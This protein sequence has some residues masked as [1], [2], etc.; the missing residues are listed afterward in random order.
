MRWMDAPRCVGCGGPTRFVRPGVPSAEERAGGAGRVELYSCAN[1]PGL[2][3][4]FPRYNACITLARTR[5]GRCGEWANLFT[6]ICRALGL[7][8]R[9]VMDWTDHVRCLSLSLCMCHA[10]RLRIA[11]ALIVPGGR[12]GKSR[13][14]SLAQVWTEVY[15]PS[16]ERYVH[17]DPCEASLDQ[18]L[19]YEKGWNKKLSFVVAFGEAEVVDVTRRYTRRFAE[20]LRRRAAL[21][22]DEHWARA[23]LAR[24]HAAAAPARRPPLARRLAEQLQLFFA[25]RGPDRPGETDAL[26]GRIS[27][28]AEWRAARGEGGT[29]A[30]WAGPD[31]SEPVPRDPRVRAALAQR[32][33]SAWHLTPARAAED[34]ALVG[35][36]RVLPQAV[37]L[38]PRLQSQVGAVWR[39]QPLR[40]DAAFALRAEVQLSEHGADGMALCIQVRRPCEPSSV[41]CAARCRRAARDCRRSARTAAVL[42]TRALSVA[43]RSSWCVA[44]LPRIIVLSLCLSL[45]GIAAQDTYQTVDRT[46]DPSGNHVALMS[47][48]LMPATA[49]HARGELAHSSDVPVLN[50]GRPHSLRL[51]YLPPES[52]GGGGLLLVFLDRRPEPLL[53]HSLSAKGL[54]DLLGARE[55]FVGFTAATG[56][57]FQEHDLLSWWIIQARPPDSSSPVDPSASSSPPIPSHLSSSPAASRSGPSASSPAPESTSPAAPPQSVSSS[58]SSSSPSLSS[59]SSSPLLANATASL[60]A[61]PSPQAPPKP[62][63]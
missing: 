14:L 20:C 51:E 25:G 39:R 10:Y 19:L 50:D 13:C 7:D 58:S 28:S 59:S 55:A 47:A 33:A 63:S 35:S 17:L 62:D 42:A 22:V 9:L 8:A 31:A 5:I 26:G 60:P 21:G 16:E 54:A 32:P 1:C 3:T 37:R 41:A 36:A 2:E 29:Q 56:G 52:A 40:L 27:G 38:T 24:F 23:C 34:L 45:S 12:G 57:L 46:A 48:G 30:S 11:R 43:S 49:N 18:P 53:A 61:I 6:G 44:S 15:L 4:R